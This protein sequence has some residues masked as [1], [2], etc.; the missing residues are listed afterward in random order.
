MNDRTI[1]LMESSSD[2]SNWTVHRLKHV[3]KLHWISVRTNGS[4]SL[5][6]S[7]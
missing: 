5:L 1:S 2:L 6:H 3:M 4:E 7:L